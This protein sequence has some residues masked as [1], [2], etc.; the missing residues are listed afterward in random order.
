MYSFLIEKFN[1]HHFVVMLIFILTYIKIN[2]LFKQEIFLKLFNA[3]VKY[4]G[5]VGTILIQ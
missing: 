2:V 5:T 1:A 4:K 3:F